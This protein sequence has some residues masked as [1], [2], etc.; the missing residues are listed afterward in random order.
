MSKQTV[1]ITGGAGFI[2]LHVVPLLLDK[3]YRV[4]IFDNMFRGDRD[5]VAKLAATGDVELVDQDVRYGGAVHAAMKGCD[6]VVHLA[7]VSINKS[8]ADPYESIDINMV[9]NH[10]VFAAAADHGVKRLVFASSASVYGDPK[11][12]PMH[13]DD[14]LDPLTPYCISKR[15]GEDLLAFYQR[16]KGLNWIALR[17]FNVYGPGQKPTAYYTSV[18]NHFVK[19]LK[20]GQPPVIDGRGE[21][22]MDFIHVHDIARSVVAA[23]EAEQGNVPVNIGTGIDTSVATLA[24]ILI[25]AVGVDVE[26]QFN[27]R[28]VLVSRR[29]A[30]I[31]RAREVLGWEPTIAVE[32]GM[33]DLI[34][35]EVA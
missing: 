20:T 17:F 29:A 34:K 9:G 3:G 1:F 28:E 14:R 31:T 33:T 12:L 5:Q 13:E 32:D 16:S 7:A 15:A 19:R 8:Q 25:K 35:V 24:E 27:P 11:K 30:D 4:R 21:Q 26:P 23:L 2:G 18:I 22:S 10:N 6:L